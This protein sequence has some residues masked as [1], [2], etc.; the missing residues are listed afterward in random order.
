[1]VAKKVH[2]EH[3]SEHHTQ[4]YHDPLPHVGDKQHAEQAYAADLQYRVSD[5]HR[6]HSE[7][8]YGSPIVVHPAEEK[9]SDLEYHLKHETH[10]ELDHAYD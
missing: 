9:H 7:G 2:R 1:M 5:A 8:K 3:E 6:H 10:H 4:A